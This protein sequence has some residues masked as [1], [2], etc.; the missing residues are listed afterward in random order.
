VDRRSSKVP[1]T[2]LLVS[3]LHPVR[4]LGLARGCRR[5]WGE[6]VG[7]PVS[8]WHFG[9]DILRGPPALF[10]KAHS[11]YPTESSSLSRQSTGMEDMYGA[12]DEF[13]EPDHWSFEGFSDGGRPG[14]LSTLAFGNYESKIAALDVI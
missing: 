1:G 9:R 5:K 14:T 4:G 7:Y 3:V 12:P 6:A 13:P 2:T 10:W 8:F 11:G